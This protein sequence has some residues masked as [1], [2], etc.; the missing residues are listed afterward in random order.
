MSA[1]DQ[2]VANLERKL[3][4]LEKKIDNK[5]V[6]GGKGILVNASNDQYVVSQSEEIQLGERLPFTLFYE[7]LKNEKVRWM[8]Y[9]GLINNVLADNF[10]NITTVRKED[11]TIK[12]IYYTIQTTFLGIDRFRID[13]SDDLPD[14]KIDLVKNATPKILNGMIGIIQGNNILFQIAK[15]NFNI[16]VEQKF[17]VQNVDGSI[18]YYYSFNINELGSPMV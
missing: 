3:Q 4:L 1:V 14:T 2:K 18:D 8:C 6:V 16:S 17:N 15:T 5:K 10:Q 7:E 12:Y 9:G 13:A 11:D